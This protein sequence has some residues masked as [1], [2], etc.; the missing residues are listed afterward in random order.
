MTFPN[1]KKKAIADV[2]K[3]YVELVEIDDP[4]VIKRQLVMS[5]TI[6]KRMGLNGIA[7][8]YKKAFRRIKI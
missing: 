3:K 2:K 4:A 5:Y 6:S 1:T 8:V 7:S